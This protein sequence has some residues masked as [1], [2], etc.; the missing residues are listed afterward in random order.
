LWWIVLREA[1]AAG[2]TVA[3]A[4]PTTIK[5]FATGAGNAD[6]DRMLLTTARRFDWFDGDNNEADALWACAIGHQLMG[7]PIVQMPAE[8]VKVLE[9]VT[10]PT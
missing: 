5:K 1:L 10:W 7:H 2:I 6:K 3:V 8:N 9:K 4:P